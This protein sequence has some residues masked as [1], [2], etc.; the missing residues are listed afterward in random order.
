MGAC[1]PLITFITKLRALWQQ[2]LP[3]PCLW[4]ALS[5][6]DHQ[7]MLCHA[8]QQALPHFPYQL[9]H[10]NLLWLPAVSSGLS[11]PHFNELLSL[12]WYQLPYQHWITRWK[13]HADRYAERLLLLQFQQLLL[14]YKASSGALP[15]A[16]VFVPMSVAKER[17]RGFNQAKVL[18]QAAA[19]TLQLPLLDVVKRHKQTVAQ[20]GLSRQQ[21]QRNLAGAFS[22]TSNIKLPAH[23]AIVD[24]V[25]TTGAT[26]NQLCRLLQ[27]HGV[28]QLSVWT[29][30]VTA[31]P[32]HSSA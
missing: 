6:D 18:A 29:L 15:D 21:R 16:I 25:I 17:K 7:H 20:V 28:T 24:D 5:V 31:N 3:S 10:Y 1:N 23:V 13:F 14:A 11:T 22:L 26:A 19:N 9:C 30:A 4:C 12:S 2:L 32:D 8:C 27:K